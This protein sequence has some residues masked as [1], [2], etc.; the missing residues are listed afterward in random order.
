[1]IKY[2][3]IGDEIG[4]MKQ[5]EDELISKRQLVMWLSNMQL[6]TDPHTEEGGFEWKVLEEVRSYVMEMSGVPIGRSD[7][8]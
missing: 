7:E 4:R 3:M 1:M 2:N 6:G 8:K 5:P